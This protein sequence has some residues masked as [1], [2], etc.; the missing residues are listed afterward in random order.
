MN[1]L[2]LGT[3]QFGLDYGINNKLG[4][5]SK[6]EIEKILDLAFSSGIDCLDTAQAYGDSET[7]L[8]EILDGG[9]KF[10][11]ISKLDSQN[12]RNVCSS[13][14]TSLKNL[15]VNQLY[16]FLYHDFNSYKNNV[17]SIKY[18][19][20]YKSEGKIN[21][22]GFSLYYP[23]QLE[24]LLNENI[25]VDL[26]QVPYNIF[27]RR[28]ELYFEEAKKRDIEIHIRSV[29]LQGCFFIDPDKLPPFLFKIKNKIVKLRKLSE[30][31]KIPLNSLCLN[32][33]NINE[34]IDKIVIGVDTQDNLR[35]NVEALNKVEEFNILKNEMLD[36]QEED[37]K[38]IL[39]FNWG[40]E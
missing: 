18:L 35:D 25:P 6:S 21:K 1:K 17:D 34:Y 4:Q 3:V 20:D 12:I 19:L 22:I 16:G 9:K 14:E 13:F 28:F 37:E 11:I 39:P 30:H 27:D 33:A 7:I 32:F 31:N 26:I 5:T 2:A 23:D 40:K 8:G 10:N 38:I 15:R 36:L 29:F 24:F